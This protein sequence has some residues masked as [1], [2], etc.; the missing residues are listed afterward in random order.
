ME[1][2]LL[3]KEYHQSLKVISLS[4][5]EWITG[6]ER[7]ESLNITDENSVNNNTIYGI[8]KFVVL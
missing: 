6:K 4:L 7:E 8:I 5:T 2:L 3:K 1:L